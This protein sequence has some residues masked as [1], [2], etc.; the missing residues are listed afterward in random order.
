MSGRGSQIF[1]VSRVWELERQICTAEPETGLGSGAT[2]NSGGCFVEAAYVGKTG[3]ATWEGS[4]QS[5]EFGACPLWNSGDA[6]SKK[7]N[8]FI[9]FLGTTE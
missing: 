5:L 9:T 2:S 6:S 4:C 8:V 3:L 7:L 1:S